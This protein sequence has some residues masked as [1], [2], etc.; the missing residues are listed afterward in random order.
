MAVTPNG[1]KLYVTNYGQ[2]GIGVIDTATDTLIRVIQSPSNAGVIVTTGSHAYLTVSGS[3]WVINTQLGR[4]A[5][6]DSECD[7]CR[8][9]CPQSGWSVGLRRRKLV[10]G[11]VG[12]ITALAVTPDSGTLYA[13]PEGVVIDSTSQPPNIVFAINLDSLTVSAQIRVGDWPSSVTVTP[14][15]AQAYVTNQ[16]PSYIA[17]A[18]GA[19]DRVTALVETGGFP[20]CVALARNSGVLWVSNW[21]GVTVSA[22]DAGANAILATIPVV[23]QNEIDFQVSD[24]VVSPDESTVYVSVFNNSSATQSS[25]VAAI[26]TSSYTVTLTSPSTG[27]WD[28]LYQGLAI[29]A[30]G[31]ILYVV[32]DNPAPGVLVMNAS[33]LAITATLPV[34]AAYVPAN[35]A[36]TGTARNSM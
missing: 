21:G 5:C 1:K 18:N 20:C 34:N 3:V 22:I 11:V 36:L 27:N 2:G 10:P 30:D 28:D 7:R 32:S 15:G 6:H 16:G 14:D 13:I 29:S 25:Y 24:L 12:E 35:L 9:S 23:S 8:I 26:S 33:T 17:A 19:T 4:F 31:T